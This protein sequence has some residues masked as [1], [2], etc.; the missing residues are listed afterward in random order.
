MPRIASA[1]IGGG[2]AGGV[3]DDL[4]QA[5]EGGRR[6]SV[7]NVSFHKQGGRGDRSRRGGRNR[8]GGPGGGRGGSG[9]PKKDPLR[10]FKS[11]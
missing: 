11:R 4:Q 10:T 2:A 9:K 6:S 8:R 7:G 5:G 3:G 1:A